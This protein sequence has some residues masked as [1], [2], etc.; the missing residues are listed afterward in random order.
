MHEFTQ[1]PRLVCALALTLSLAACGG[2]SGGS[3]AAL[4]ASSSS[5]GAAAS[6]QKSDTAS[7]ASDTSNSSSDVSYAP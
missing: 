3:A 4:G 1:F 7:S 2:D 6:S 5:Q